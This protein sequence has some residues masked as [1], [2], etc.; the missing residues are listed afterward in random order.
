MDDGILSHICKPGYRITESTDR[1]IQTIIDGGANIGDE[2][3]R[4][5]HFHLDAE[6]L[7]I[8]AAPSNF[9]LLQRN[10]ADD[11]RTKCFLR[12]I[13]STPGVLSLVDRGNA[14]SFRVMVPETPDDALAEAITIEQ[15]MVYANWTHVDILKFG[16]DDAEGEVFVHANR[17]VEKIGRL[18][19]GMNVLHAFQ[20]D[21]FDAFI[22]GENAILIRRSTG[23]KVET[24]PWL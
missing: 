14:E 5:R 9:A 10:F 18:I 4:F 22:G 20:P 19:S 1:P 11:A 2:T 6:I 23:W 12:A 15:L 13:W 8:E 17:W 3:L 7:A 16:L 24:I 21:E